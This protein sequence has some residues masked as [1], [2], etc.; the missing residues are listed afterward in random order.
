MG[1]CTSLIAR[2]GPCTS[3]SRPNHTSQTAKPVI[4]DHMYLKTT[5]EFVYSISCCIYSLANCTY[6]HHNK[7]YAYKCKQKFCNF[8]INWRSCNFIS[9]LEIVLI[10]SKETRIVTQP[11][12]YIRGHL[13][14]N[15]DCGSL[16][17]SKIAIT[18]FLLMLD[19]FFL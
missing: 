4:K 11:A 17:D 5:L 13:M 8:I 2:M 6:G 14:T 1:P 19:F 10:Q 18:K 16:I 7:L 9:K 15:S 3:H 12:D